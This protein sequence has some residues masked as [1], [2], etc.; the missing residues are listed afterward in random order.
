MNGGEV[1]PLMIMLTAGQPRSRS[2]D[3]LS[4][5]LSY[6]DWEK[7]RDEIVEVASQSGPSLRL[8]VVSNLASM[9]MTIYCVPRESGGA[10]M[11]SRRESIAIA[12][13][14]GKLSVDEYA[15]F[16]ARL[17]EQVVWPD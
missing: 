12:A 13:G 14:R 5:P 15:A 10:F 2:H 1:S 8:D 4:V 16:L 3:L 17:G 9:D 11:W 6:E 7:A